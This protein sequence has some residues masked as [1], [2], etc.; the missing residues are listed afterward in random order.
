MNPMQKVRDGALI[1]SY[2]NMF[3]CSVN[4]G[5][6]ILLAQ[7]DYMGR[8]GNET[9]EAALEEKYQGIEIKLREMLSVYE[10][11]MRHPYLL[12]RDLVDAGIEPGP[13]INEA[14]SYAHKLRLNGKS[15]EDQLK[16]TLG[17]IRKRQKR[18]R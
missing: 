10:E 16:Q 18:H 12:G 3:D 5:D 7:A 6:L 4:P 2:M 8:K 11:R 15:K 9:D 14:L 17:W 13:V 1:K